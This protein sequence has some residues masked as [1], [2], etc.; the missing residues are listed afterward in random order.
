MTAVECYFVDAVAMS[1]KFYL[2]RMDFIPCIS[3]SLLLLHQQGL[4]LQGAQ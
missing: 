2:Y 1:H 4:G 3:Y